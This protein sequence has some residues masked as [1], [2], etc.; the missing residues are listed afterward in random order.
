MQNMFYKFVGVSSDQ[1]GSLISQMSWK[2]TLISKTPEMK[3]FGFARNKI[4]HTK[5]I[6]IINYLLEA[7]QL[8]SNEGKGLYVADLRAIEDRQSLSYLFSEL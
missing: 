8:P 6:N 2:S 3:K 5:D 1:A 7:M 4:I